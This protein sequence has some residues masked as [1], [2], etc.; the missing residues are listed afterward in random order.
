MVIVSVMYPAAD[1]ASF[2]IDYYLKTHVPMAG[3]RWKDCGLREAKVLRG[4]S[5]PGGGAP[6]YL[7]TTLLTFDSAAAFETALER[8]G[9]EII[10]DLPNFTNIQPV[11]Q[12]NDVLM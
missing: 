11:I 3:T 5:A 2:D 10:G 4:S 8:H 9:Q 12:V 7:I 6:P 1:G